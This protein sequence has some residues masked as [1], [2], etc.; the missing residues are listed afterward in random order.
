MVT[1]VQGIY[2]NGHIELKEKP[3]VADETPVLVTFLA[4]STDAA[5]SGTMM[6]FGMLAVPGRRMSTEKDFKHAE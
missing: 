2:R 1:S 5:D 4:K 3:E 6:T